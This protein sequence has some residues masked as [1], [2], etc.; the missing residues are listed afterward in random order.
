MAIGA[1]FK[2]ITPLPPPSP[3]PSL[4]FNGW[5]TANKLT[6]KIEKYCTEELGLA[7]GVPY[8][9]Y[10]QHGTCLKGL[11]EEGILAD[12]DCAVNSF[13]EAVHDISLDDIRPDPELR[14]MLLRI[15]KPRW[16]FTASVASHAQRCLEAL[17]IDD[18]F[19]GIIDC[20]SCSLAT[21][22]SPS[23]FQDAMRIAGVD[24]GHRCLFM[25]DSVK[26]IRT[27]NALGWHTI[28]VG[29]TSRDEGEPIVCPQ[30]DFSIQTIHEMPSVVPGIFRSMQ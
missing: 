23:A 13:L 7:P 30:A 18:L 8:A 1:V 19:L 22:H 26:N 25:D 15:D 10:K 20:K 11:I 24:E 12:T 16:V 21:K 4:Y 29:L 14:A 28:L 9:L 5:S 2:T 3:P 6:E 17:A 27:A